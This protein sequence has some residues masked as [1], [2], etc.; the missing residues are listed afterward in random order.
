VS[1]DSLLDARWRLFFDWASISPLSNPAHAARRSHLERADRAVDPPLFLRCETARL[2]RLRESLRRF[3]TPPDDHAIVLGRSAAELLSLLATG[4]PTTADRN[5]VVLVEPNHPVAALAWAGTARTRPIRVHTVP[6][7]GRHLADLDALAAALDRRCL[8]VCVTH[9]THLHG[10]VQPIRRI[11]DLAHAAG[12][13]CVVDG[14][15]ATGRVLVD[16]AALGCDVYIGVGRKAMLA[17]IGTAFLSGAAEVLST[18]E[19]SVWSTRSAT[20]TGPDYAA[21]AVA[22]RP[23]ELP[24]R[25]EGNLP[26]LAALNALFGSTDALLNIGVGRMQAQVR[27]LLPYLL[28]GMKRNGFKLTSTAGISEIENA[29]IVTFAAPPTAS[30]LDLQ[31]RC[32]AA[33][34][35]VAADRDTVRVSLH[36]RNDETAIDALCW[37]MR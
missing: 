6:H 3:L 30:G 5:V 17:P 2:D 33:G 27:R 11:A 14:A 28:D 24:A 20:L 4:L 16:V 29:G 15:Q 12:A 10:G 26:D 22:A 19:P 8:A 9:V 32:A 7:N 36:A 37:E 34:I 23:C 25:L 35:V 18:V 21:S 13:L 1:V 31:A